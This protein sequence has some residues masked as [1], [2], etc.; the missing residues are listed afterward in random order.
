MYT[1][2][3]HV[4]RMKN[5]RKIKYVMTDDGGNRETRKTM[6]RIEACFKENSSLHI[7]KQKLDSNSWATF[8][9]Q[10]IS[11]YPAKFPNVIVD[12]MSL[13]EVL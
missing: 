3:G 4:Y 5:N 6:Q 12:E 9:Y 1:Q 2:F 13:D 11:I 10:K 7:S 8:F